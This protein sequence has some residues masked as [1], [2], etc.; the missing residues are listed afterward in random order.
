M[1]D[2]LRSA[3]QVLTPRGLIIDLHPSVNYQPSLAIRRGGRRLAVGR[4]HREPDQ[5]VAAAERAVRQTV[6]EGLFEVVARERTPWVSHY[7]HVDDLTRLLQLNANWSIEP[8][9]RRRALRL[10]R[11]DEGGS[12][13]ISRTY[14]LVVLR[15]R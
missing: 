4:I 9:I 8:R 6:R 13:E 5:D 11:D 2:A 14:A 3:G 7:P 10:W 1:V 12:I 15:A